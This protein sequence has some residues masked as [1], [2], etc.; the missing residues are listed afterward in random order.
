MST[1]SFDFSP[2]GRL[3]FEHV[4]LESEKVHPAGASPIDRTI[5]HDP[6]SINFGRKK[7]HK[8]AAAERMLAGPTIDWLVAFPAELRP[9]ALCERYPHVANRLAQG[10]T[11]VA[12]SRVAVQQL[13]EDARWGSVGYAGQVQLELQRLFDLL[14]GN[15]LPSSR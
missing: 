15:A 4:E 3:E 6:L 8:P 12:R 7:D 5:D 10:W 2:S 14:S 11:H 13:A 1:E 9:K